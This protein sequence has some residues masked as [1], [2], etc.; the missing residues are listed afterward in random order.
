M[1]QATLP[2]LCESGHQDPGCHRPCA[3]GATTGVLPAR[4]LRESGHQDPGCHR[5]CAGGATTG[6]LPGA[7]PPD[8]AATGPVPVEPQLVCYQRAPL[9]ESGHQDPGCHRPC[10]GGATTGVL[11]ARC[12][13][14]ERP[15]RSRLPPALCRWSHNWRA[16][17]A[18]ASAREWPPRSRLPP[19][20]CRWSHNWRA[21]RRGALR[22]SGHQDPGC[23]RPCAGGATTGVLPARRS[24]RE[25]P[26][27]SRLPPALCRWS[28]NR[29]ATRLARER[30]P[31]SRLPPALCRWSHN[32]CYQSVPARAATKIQ[33]ATGPVPVEPQLA[34]YQCRRSARERPPRSRLP[35]ALCRWSHNWRATRRGRSARERPPRSRLPP[36]L[37]RW[38][39]NWRATRRGRSARERPPRSR[40]PPAL[41]RWSHNWRATRRAPCARAATKIQ[42]ATGPVPVEP[43]LACYQARRYAP[44]ECRTLLRQSGFS[45]SLRPILATYVCADSMSAHG[46]GGG[47]DMSSIDSAVS[48]AVNMKQ[49]ALRSEIGIA[50]AGKLLDAQRMEGDAAVELIENAAQITKAAGKGANFDGVA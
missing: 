7:V 39:H 20:L 10:A 41:C 26:P 49:M 45:H 6:V 24:A 1:R 30:P 17:S 43:Q 32:W 14:R 47:R 21:T 5:P 48:G 40:L 18:G 29:R 27:R 44:C 42:A 37:C 35:P 46:P 23:H 3:G 4:R 12:L 16:T 33:A 31:R 13:S 8:Q 11:P 15:P 50:V 36:A 2:A 38:S 9:R 22:E 19:A 25:R 28:H 34:C